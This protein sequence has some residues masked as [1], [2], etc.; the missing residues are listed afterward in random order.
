MSTGGG[1]TKT[2]VEANV[3]AKLVEHPTVV[4]HPTIIA[5]D[6]TASQTGRW[7]KLMETP[8]RA[9]EIGDTG[10]GNH[11]MNLTLLIR[12]MSSKVI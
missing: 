12:A 2:T 10:S 3:E 7:I 4:E 9:L 6:P 8:T 11:C 1:P 5:G